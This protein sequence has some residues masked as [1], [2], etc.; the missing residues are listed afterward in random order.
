VWVSKER[1]HGARTA[2]VRWSCARVHLRVGRI[3]LQGGGTLGVLNYT[4]SGSYLDNGR[5]VEGSRFLGDSFHANLGVR[6]IDA[7]GR[8]A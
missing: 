6:P 4:A 7:V 1:S 5:P 2:L 3:L 8:M